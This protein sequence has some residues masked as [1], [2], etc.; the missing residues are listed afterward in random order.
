MSVPIWYCYS[1]GLLRKCYEKEIEMEN[2]ITGRRYGDE[3][4]RQS[5]EDLGER[6]VGMKWKGIN[7]RETHGGE[8]KKDW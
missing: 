2:K 8:K 6:R 4:G 5:V 7:G 1:V 3:V